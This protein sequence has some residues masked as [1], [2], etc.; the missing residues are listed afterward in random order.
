MFIAEIGLN[1]NGSIYAAKKLIKMAKDAG[2]DVVKFQKRTPDITVPEH[3]KTVMRKTPW[4]DMTYLDYKKHIEFGK[5]AYDEIDKYCKHIGIQW[6]ASVWDIP[7][8]DFIMNYNV[9][10]IKIPSANLTDDE[11]LKAI[12]KTEMPVVLS[13]GMSKP[14]EI[15]HAMCLLH[16]NRVT[17]MLC[18]S[19]YPSLDEELDLNA[20]ET[21]REEYSEAIIGYSGHEM[22]ILPSITAYAMGAQVIERHITLDRDD[23]GT[24]QAASLEPDQL[25]E[26]IT[27]MKRINIIKGKNK[28]IV[29]PAEEI[30]KKKLR[31]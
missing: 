6:T 20:M 7:S 19:S 25:K 5:D 30:A 18:N 15:R 28:I 4:G 29:Y 12:G 21:L 23:W 8:L 24:D 16:K 2:A 17:L 26:L 3:Q 9:P 13:T 31:R 14:H 11:L 10:F 22:D 1:H 27:S